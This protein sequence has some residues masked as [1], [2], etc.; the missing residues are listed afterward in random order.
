MKAFVVVGLTIILTLTLIT[1]I[2]HVCTECC[3]GEPCNPD[4]R[5][6]QSTYSN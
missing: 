2:A 6:P 1:A 4:L 5:K 3:N